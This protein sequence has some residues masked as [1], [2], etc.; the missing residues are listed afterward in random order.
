[1]SVFKKSHNQTEKD[2]A[3][4]TQLSIHSLQSFLKNDVRV[5]CYDTIDSTN[6]EAK[7]HSDKLTD[8][9]V[10]FVAEH[11]SMGRGRLGRSFYSPECAGLYMSLM[12]KALPDADDIVCLTTATAVCVVRALKE[13][14]DIT[15]QIKWVNDI[16]L[17]SKKICG[18][19]CEAVT[20]PVSSKVDSIIIG[21]GINV[22][23]SDFPKEIQDIAGALNQ[24]IDRNRLCAK[25]TDNILE[26]VNT[27]KERSF[28]DEYKAHSLVLSR[29]ITYTQ[30]GVTKTATAIDIDKN[31]GLVIQTADGTKTLSTGEISVR[32]GK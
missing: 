10:L 24:N 29:E 11:Q 23:A 2:T 26:M 28:I 18:I 8:T 9:P 12:I 22:S 30:D 31:G 7:R 25:I 4:V 3:K 15:T 20:D 6:N 19:L 27:I 21:I 5:H 1:M 14:C 13:L 16:Y 17:S 32:I